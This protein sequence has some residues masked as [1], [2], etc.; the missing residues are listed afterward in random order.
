[1]RFR[2]DFRQ[3]LVV[4]LT[5]TLTA[6]CARQ[7]LAAAQASGDSARHAPMVELAHRLAEAPR[8]DAVAAGSEPAAPA[9]QTPIVASEQ[10]PLAP[11]VAPG[12]SEGQPAGRPGRSWVL[13]TLAALAVVILAVFGARAVL[14]RWSGSS[15]T[16]GGAPGVEVLARVGVGPR[17]Q[18]LLLR[19]AQRVL[20]VGQTP[21]ELSRL[22]EIADAQEV[23]DILAAVQRS[24][25]GSISQGFGQLLQ[26]FHREH[27]EHESPEGGQIPAD[28]TEA[29]T[30]RT[31]DGVSS[32]LS[33]LRRLGGREPGDRP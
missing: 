20:V 21:A 14:R 12:S 30:D 9:P 23:A 22:A 25:P 24:R 11:G 15:G 28:A 10:R 5:V 18:V 7:A 29:I 2:T 17:Q 16:V 33:R 8:A 26:R 1:M 3:F 32:L 27:A 31:R 19:L 13:D 6:C 4:A